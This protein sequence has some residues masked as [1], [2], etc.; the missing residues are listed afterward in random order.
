[1]VSFCETRNWSLQALSFIDLKFN[2][3]F[4]NAKDYDSICFGSKNAV[5]FYLSK[6]SIPSN[7]Q[8]ACVGT[9]TSNALIKAGYYPHF[10]GKKSGDPAQVAVGLKSFIGNK[11]CFFPVS[12]QSL[13]T[14]HVHFDEDQKIVRV[15]Y[16]TLVTPSKIDEADI[17]IFTSPSNVE[18]FTLLNT[19]PKN[20]QFIAWGNSTAEKMR[21]SNM[22]PDVVLSQSQIQELLD[23]LAN[24]NVLK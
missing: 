3:Q 1:M 7:I 24:M 21:A 19:I 5:N 20:G 11:K 16:H 4:Q 12:D 6:Y 10:I 23:S 15:L 8:I 18:S 13:G 2:E 17:Y 14:L 22:I 9:S